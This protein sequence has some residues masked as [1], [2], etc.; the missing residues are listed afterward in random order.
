M[1]IHY[2]FEVIFTVFY[3]QSERHHPDV[4]DDGSKNLK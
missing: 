1:I 3:P 4:I 2:C